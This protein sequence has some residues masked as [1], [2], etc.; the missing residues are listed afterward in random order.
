MSYTLNFI[1]YLECID[2]VDILSCTASTT[3]S[4]D[5][6]CEFAYDGNPTTGWAADT[7]GSGVWIRVSFGRVHNVERILI[8]PMSDQPTESITDVLLEFVDEKTLEY[9]LNKYD[10]SW[11][12]VV[13]AN[14]VIS[15]FVKI[16]GKTVN[17]K[18][19]NGFDEIEVFV[20]ILGSL[21]INIFIII[22]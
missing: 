3:H 21:Y 13:L 19:N 14:L 17:G 20:C 11:N 6:K 9:S 12:E 8:K 10:G 1:F 16:I 22:I 15:N 2:K 4:D 7:H 18:D 5:N